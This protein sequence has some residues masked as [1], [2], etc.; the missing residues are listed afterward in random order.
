MATAPDDPILDGVVTPDGA[1]VIDRGQVA[2]LGVSPGSH[3]ALTPVPRGRIRSY[4]GAGDHLGPAPDL[5]DFRE[6]R[7]AVWKGFGE[8]VKP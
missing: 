2:R 3:V 4:L 6:V 5:G 1:I 7:E 8:G